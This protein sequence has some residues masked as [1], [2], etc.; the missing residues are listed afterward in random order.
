MACCVCLNCFVR[1]A[2]VQLSV[3][4]SLENRCSGCCVPRL[5]CAQVQPSGLAL[6]L[7]SFSCGQNEKGKFSEVE[8]PFLSKIKVGNFSFSFSFF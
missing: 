4:V 8:K 2:C 3:E 7:S 5:S 6:R 1:N